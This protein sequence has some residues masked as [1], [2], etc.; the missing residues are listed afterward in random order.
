MITTDQGWLDV[1]TAL[2]E[3]G[4]GKDVVDLPARA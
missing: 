2:I 3:R 4:V 1:V